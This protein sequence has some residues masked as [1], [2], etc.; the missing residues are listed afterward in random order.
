ME[1]GDDQYFNWEEEAKEKESFKS[2]HARVYTQRLLIAMVGLPAR[3]KTFIS[4]KLTRYL[5][6]L[7]YNAKVFNIG[8]KRRK[9][10]GVED[11]ATTNFFDPENKEGVSQ[12]EQVAEDT[13]T[14][15]VKFLNHGT[16]NIAL[17]DG[18]NTTKKRRK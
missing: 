10:L 11:T 9:V 18:T 15:V 12:R 14:D 5:T 13:L 4:R 17:F 8:D 2:T 6:W 7:G 16:G 3:G 1:K